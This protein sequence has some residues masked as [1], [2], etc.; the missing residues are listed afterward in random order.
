MHIRAL[1]SDKAQMDKVLVNVWPFLYF[2]D[3]FPLQ[4]LPTHKLHAILQKRMEWHDANIAI[5]VQMWKDCVDPAG[6][7]ALAAPRLSLGGL[8]NTLPD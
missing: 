7:G 2:W 1:F 5:F 4:V 8:D 3:V 6:A